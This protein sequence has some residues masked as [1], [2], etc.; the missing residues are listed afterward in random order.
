MLG[1]QHRDEAI[2]FRVAEFLQRL[3]A[4]VTVQKQVFPTS[5]LGMNHERLDQPDQGIEET[6]ALYRPASLGESLI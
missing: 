3:V 1:K 5:A 2:G 4:H 6:M